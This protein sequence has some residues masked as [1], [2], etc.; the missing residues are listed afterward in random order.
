[1][2]NEE[3]ASLIAACRRELDQI[4]HFREDVGSTNSMMALMTK[5]SVVKC[6]GTIEQC[7]KGILYDFFEANNSPQAKNYI[8][9]HFRKSSM[10]PNHGN[11]CGALKKFDAGWNDA[12]ARK[13]D[14]LSDK[15]KVL[16]SL[17]DL[18]EARNRFAH[19]GSPTTSFDQA[20]EYF[21]D[22]CKIIGF[23]DEIVAQEL[24]TTSESS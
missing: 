8:Y 23:I 2:Q 12:L 4:E 15:T 11:I 18:N 9:E 10:N 1:M 20:K 13:M 14:S 6:C 7:F 19:G 24:S 3:A 16:R 21:E 22:S 17:K 5:Y